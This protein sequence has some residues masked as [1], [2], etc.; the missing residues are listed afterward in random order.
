MGTKQ[1]LRRR[2]GKTRKI[3]HLIDH[4][5]IP[6]YEHVDKYQNKSKKFITSKCPTILDEINVRQNPKNISEVT[7]ERTVTVSE[8]L[9]VKKNLAKEFNEYRNDI[10]NALSRLDKSINSRSEENSLSS[11]SRIEDLL[12]SP[13]VKKIENIEKEKIDCSFEA[14]ETLFLASMVVPASEQYLEICV[15]LMYLND[16]KEEM[17]KYFKEFEEYWGPK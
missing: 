4:G 12:K 11:I 2:E 6:S 8:R 5:S 1:S 13:L 14:L 3:Q 17:K 9:T 15:D 7:Y 16:K 10:Y